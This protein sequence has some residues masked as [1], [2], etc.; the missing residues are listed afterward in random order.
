M[1]SINTRPAHHLAQLSYC[2]QLLNKKNIL[3]LGGEYSLASYLAHSDTACVIAVSPDA[4]EAAWQSLDDEVEMEHVVMSHDVLDFDDG[5]FDAV[6]IP[7]LSGLSNPIVT[8]E[9]AKRVLQPSGIVI[10]ASPN[11]EASEASPDSKP[12]DYYALYEVMAG[13]F[14]SVQMIG[15]SPFAGYAVVDL[16]CEDE[17]IEINFDAEL[18]A[19]ETE[20][21]EWFIAVCGEVPA[22][23]E[24]YFI[25]QVP[26]A[27][28]GMGDPEDTKALTE[29]SDQL[30]EARRELGNRGVRIES[31]EKK[32]EEE[33]M[34]SEE[35]RARAVKLSKEL[36]DERR[37]TTKK[38]LEDEFTK[39]SVD[40]DLQGELRETQKQLRLAEQRATSAEAGRDELIERMRNDVA[41]LDRLRDRLQKLDEKPRQ[42]ARDV[43]TLKQLRLAEER[44]RSA[45]AARDELIEKM[46]SD[47]KALDRL[48]NRQDSVQERIRS[49]E[50]RETALKSE[51]TQ[52]VKAHEER[53]SALTGEIAALRKQLEQT[54]TAE[55]SARA[56]VETA[57]TADE[58]VRVA[59][60]RARAAEESVRA[61]EEKARAAEEKARA[62]AEQ[63]R[64]AEERVR[65]AEEQARAATEQARTAEQERPRSEEKSRSEEE[66]EPSAPAADS[67]LSAL[68]KEN[69]L[70]EERLRETASKRQRAEAEIQR[71]EA[72]VRDLIVRLEDGGVAVETV[73][74]DTSCEEVALKEQVESLEAEVA[75]LMGARSGQHRARVEAEL[76]LSM[77]A[78]KLAEAE[79]A[80]MAQDVTA[81]NLADGS[82]LSE[83]ERL[84]K[85]VESLE[86]EV[87]ALMG[88]RSGQHRARVE[89][90]LELS[91]A[92]IRLQD[93]EEALVSQG[94]AL[95]AKEEALE[96][97]R[98]EIEALNQAQSSGDAAGLKVAELEGEL[99][100]CRWRI[101]ELEARNQDL[102]A[103]CG[104]AAAS[105]G[106]AAEEL[107]AL[108]DESRAQVAAHRERISALEIALG[109]RTESVNALFETLENRLA[110]N[111]GG[112]DRVTALAE[113]NR[114]LSAALDAAER[115]E[116]M[117]DEEIESKEDRAAR[118]RTDL[119]RAN[120]RVAELEQEITE[121][122][123]DRAR[124][125]RNLGEISKALDEAREE[126]RR[127]KQRAES[128]EASA[129]EA[130]RRSDAV[131]IELRGARSKIDELTKE[132]RDRERDSETRINEA[133]KSA[134]EDKGRLEGLKTELERASNEL[135][136]EI[137]K[138][139][140][141]QASV[142]LL[143]EQLASEAKISHLAGADAARTSGEVG[144]LR[145][146]LQ[147]HADELKEKEVEIETGLRVVA[148]LREEVSRLVSRLRSAKA[149]EVASGGD[150]EATAAETE[151]LTAETE[152]LTAEVET[153]TARTE[154]L[155]AETESLTARTEVLTAEVEALRAKLSQNEADFAQMKAEV[156][157]YRDKIRT[158]ED[159]ISE[160]QEMIAEMEAK[161]VAVNQSKVGMS[162]ELADAIQQSERLRLELN[163]VKAKESSL[164]AEI[165][166]LRAKLEQ[167]EAESREAEEAITEIKENAEGVEA[168]RQQVE[169]KEKLVG[170]LTDQLEERER[171]AATL[172]RKNR[173][174]SEQIREHESDVSAWNMEL[175]L[176]SARISQLERELA[177]ARQRK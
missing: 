107:L 159:E 171:R 105:S 38:Q 3:L 64:T 101:D 126:A 132:M 124:F 50:D 172:E 2:L 6:V 60:E 26:K 63:V 71:L 135:K 122:K 37:A 89:A 61:A 11:P 45:E 24:P 83:V 88:A 145:L 55:E 32:L 18:M 56:A 125:E 123:S 130:R 68:A 162:V 150:E 112:A 31:L 119:D 12:L 73:P 13:V 25:I 173:V 86:A 49:A 78:V 22:A 97:H 17:D 148:T 94:L 98:R 41:E 160:A 120:Q 167:A 62:A 81:R 36:E 155:T 96:Q 72:L 156:A 99:Q 151:A 58:S 1:S 111:R 118:L 16:A 27:D 141:L 19:G 146:Q 143:S 14:P 158:D 52:Q 165:T 46:R 131:S 40:I 44:A 136:E 92:T 70:I 129:E 139:E 142:A 108:V 170:S 8:L 33:L 39:R 28:M 7:D 157:E 121:A 137:R 110:S 109:Q 20:A 53:V 43:E 79:A 103:R 147:R 154:A 127:T 163:Q 91:A 85:M 114:K 74:A 138:G 30:A 104:D 42:P 175:K 174:L 75:A 164:T 59:E 47:A 133:R 76:E 51:I 153:L 21:I 140:A 177:E 34:Q 9:E 66:S 5:V 10:I 113:E 67:E 169:E 4:P 80:L 54:R 29:V 87:A 102:S 100:A 90:E 117:L 84:T 144:A 35:A 23:L 128:A 82:C 77:T 168:L 152:A 15:Q 93:V 166:G 69:A 176:R 57:Q 95:R 161:V 149:V 106:D 134:A 116:R 115:R 65:A 48:R